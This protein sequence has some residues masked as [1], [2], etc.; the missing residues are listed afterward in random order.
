MSYA[1]DLLDEQVDRLG[2]S[3]RQTVGVEVGQQLDAPGVD[4]AGQTGQLGDGRVGAVG[5]PAVQVGL[6]A[7]AVGAG[8]DQP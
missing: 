4:R 8:E 7:G 6:R 5:Q 1:L 3:V 2:G